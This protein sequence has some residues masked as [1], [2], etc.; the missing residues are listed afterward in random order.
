MH[1]KAT[2]NA[3]APAKSVGDPCAYYETMLPQWE[4]VRAACAGERAVVAYDKDKGLDVMNF[5]NLLI[6]FSPSMSPAQYAFYL[7]EAEWPGVT[8]V[9]SK[10]LLGGLL[11]KSPKLTL[12]EE[13]PESEEAVQWLTNEFGQ[14]GQSLAAFLDEAVYEELQTSRAW[15]FVDYPVGPEPTSRD[16]QRERK[17]FV[18][19][20]KA[21]DVINW[22]VTNNK[23]SRVIVRTFKEVHRDED[24]FHPD[25]VQVV[26]VH[27]LFED[28]Y[29]VRVFEK[30]AAESDV[31]VRAGVRQ[32]KVS[33]EVFE[34]IHTSGDVMIN[35]E[36]LDFIPAWS[37][38]G[39]IDVQQP[40]LVNFVDKEVSLYNKTS[41]RNHLMYGAATYTPYI[42]SD[43][44]DSKFKEIVEQGLG[45]WLHLQK[46]DTADVLK[47]PTESLKDMEVAIS[48]AYEELARLG[49]RML[50]P[51]TAQS[52][53]ALELRNAAQSAQLGTLNTKVS[54]TL[55][56]VISFM[57]RWRYDVDIV[58]E[59]IEF[60]MSEDFNPVP[61]GAD[62]LR[63]ITEWYEKGFMPR[64]TWVLIMKL[65]DI[66]PPEYNDKEGVKEINNDS[67]LENRAT[68]S[69]NKEEFDK[70]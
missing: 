64:S 70:M 39:S 58:A 2:A 27:E 63:L 51:E 40:H 57:L 60:S 37:L 30:R 21:E 67:L 46:G 35:G 14:D 10:I 36:P 61:L 65:N 41:R 7:S 5:T 16:E 32:S 34:L 3:V 62:W 44:E 59:E 1:V 54:A 56:A 13:F 12:P 45:T 22:T 68:G 55:R 69:K 18:I 42:C 52:G 47:P 4:R 8:S 24:S 50:A 31:S 19:L 38:N 33:Q 6:P 66:L 43:M 28:K 26:H 9:Y 23:L 20:R 48:N 29:R 25:I 53:V 15:V 11:R 49:I 17:P